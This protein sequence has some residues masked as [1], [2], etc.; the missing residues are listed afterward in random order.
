MYKVQIG[1]SCPTHFFRKLFSHM[2]HPNNFS[3]LYGANELFCCNRFFVAVAVAVDNCFFGVSF[4]WIR[5]TCSL[6]LAFRVNFRSQWSHLKILSLVCNRKWHRSEFLP[7]VRLHKGHG[8]FLSLQIFHL[9]SISWKIHSASVVHLKQIKHSVKYSA[10]GYLMNSRTEN[11]TAY[12]PTKRDDRFP[13]M[14][15]LLHFLHFL[16]HQSGSNLFPFHAQQSCSYHLWWSAILAMTMYSIP[17]FRLHFRF[18]GKYR[19]LGNCPQLCMS[20]HECVGST[21]VAKWIFVR[22]NNTLKL[23]N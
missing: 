17:L 8:I 15:L 1:K 16:V 23:P 12:N 3:L 9:W 18:H 20:Y 21:L 5:R 14:C 13:R 22:K 2:E 6:R 7:K 10:W 19:H 4:K 11:H